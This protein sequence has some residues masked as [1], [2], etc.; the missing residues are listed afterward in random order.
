[1]VPQPVSKSVAVPGVHAQRGAADVGD[2]GARGGPVDRALTEVGDLVAVVARREVEADALD[3]GLHEDRALGLDEVGRHS[4]A[5]VAVRVADD[6]RG[7][8]VDDPVQGGVHVG[9]GARQGAHVDDA[10][11]GRHAVH[12]LDVEGL[13]AVPVL[14]VALGGLGDQA[15]R[16]DLRELSPGEGRDAVVFGVAIHVVDDG[17]RGIGVDD[18]HGHPAAV[19]AALDGPGHAVGAAQLSRGVAAH[20]VRLGAAV[21]LG[22]GRGDRLAPEQRPRLAVAKAGRWRRDDPAAQRVGELAALIETDHG[23]DHAGER[24][25]DAHG[26]RGR[27]QRE[28]LDAVLVQLHAEGDLGLR[29]GARGGYVKTVRRDAG[30]RESLAL[31]PAHDG[32]DVGPTGREARA[33]LRRAQVTAVARA[34]GVGD[35]LGERGDVGAV[36]PAQVDVKAHRGR[37]VGGRRQRR[38]LGPGRH[39]AA[40]LG[41]ALGSGCGARDQQHGKSRAEHERH[42]DQSQ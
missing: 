26:R 5:G 38:R 18:R 17:R 33:E 14:L 8:T 32:G 2:P 19:V 15:G 4:F 13:L 21:G 27:A 12:G 42:G 3:R 16:P 39:A 41:T 20:R 35:R 9:V 34:R 7:A 30:D 1:M 37:P 24:R 40:H 31:E 10:G 29:D 6:A 36:A 23:G 28:A 25:R 22:Q 11:A